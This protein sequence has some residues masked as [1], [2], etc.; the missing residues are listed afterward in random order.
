MSARHTLPEHRG[1]FYGGA[2]HDAEG[3]AV[4]IESPSTGESLG[5][6][7][8][9]SAADI[10]KAVSAARLGYAE[11]RRVPP[12][13]RARILREMARRLAAHGEE[14]AWIDAIDGGSPWGEL[15][16]D[17]GTTIATIEFF[18]G[19]VTE[20]KG[21]SVPMAPGAVNF[22]VREPIGVIGRIIPFNHPFMFC[23]GKSA[24]PLAAGNA[25]IVKPP[26]QASLS[27]LR[28]AEL[29]GDLF[30][31]GVFNVVTGDRSAG[32][33]L[34]G[35]E[36]VD[37]IALIGSATAG[38]AVLKAGAER[39]RQPLLE[40]GGKNAL[41]AFSDADPDAVAQAAVAGM[42]FAWCGQSCGSTSRAFLH[43][44]IHDAVVERILHH[45]RRHV[46]G[47]ATAKD[48]TMGSLVSRAHLERVKGF[49]EQGKAEGATLL[50]GGKA[51]NDPALAKGCYLEPTIFLGV[52]QQ[53]TIATEEI[54]GPVLSVLRWND[55]AK[56]LA[57]VNAPI[58]GLTCSIW[59]ND[60]AR[61]LATAEAVQAGY[62]WVNEVAKHFLGAPFGGYKQ[63]GIGRE[64]CLEEL[65]TFTQEKNIH[66]RFGHG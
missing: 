15:M 13:E 16:K 8:L 4:D 31:P 28:V 21:A 9:A 44:D 27:S 60:L 33:A 3:G 55:E 25:V 34:A 53:M 49:V 52:T 66:I 40:L 59:T 50:T 18:V 45:L 11:W 54:F 48:T 17:V 65:L 5:A 12:F 7:A 36:G 58:Y 61:A 1:L 47:L 6:Y 62:V 38:R 57:D 39:I 63:S 37:K 29:V 23:A 51:P 46:P 10:D 32:A 56:M 64:E 19:L 26:E 20:M 42:N 43:A 30:P 35:H 41:I 14:L 2:W 24:A 22:S